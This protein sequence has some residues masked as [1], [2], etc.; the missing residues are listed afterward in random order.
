V[1][2]FVNS[3]EMAQSLGAAD[4]VVSCAGATTI[5]ELSALA[6]PTILIPR[7]QLAAGHQL[8]N[9]AEYSKDGAAEVIEDEVS[10]APGLHL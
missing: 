7:A 6:K 10:I 4:I 9:A 1:V 3:E 8:K 2:S 5:L